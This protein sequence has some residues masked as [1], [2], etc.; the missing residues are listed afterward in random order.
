[1]DETGQTTDVTP[2][3]C[4][5]ALHKNAIKAGLKWRFEPVIVDGAPTPVEVNLILKITH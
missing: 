5:D 4:P 3:D 1:V 2:L